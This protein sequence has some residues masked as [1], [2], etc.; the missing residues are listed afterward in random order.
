MFIVRSKSQAV[1]RRACI[2]VAASNPQLSESDCRTLIDP[3]GY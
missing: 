1:Q 2:F 3:S